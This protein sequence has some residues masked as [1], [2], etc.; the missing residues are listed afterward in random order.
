[1]DAFFFSHKTTGAQFVLVQT[2]VGAAYFVK[3]C[4]YLFQL[5]FRFVSLSHLLNI[6][7]ITN[8]KAFKNAHMRKWGINYSVPEMWLYTNFWKVLNYV[9]SSFLRNAA[10]MYQR[11]SGLVPSG[12]AVLTEPQPQP[13][14]LLI[15]EFPDRLCREREAAELQFA[16]KNCPYPF[17]GTAIPPCFP[18]SLPY[19]RSISV[20]ATDV[21]GSS[22]EYVLL[23]SSPDF[24]V[25]RPGWH[26]R[27]L[28][29]RL[30]N[31]FL[32][33]FENIWN[34][35]SDYAK[36]CTMGNAVCSWF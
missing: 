28:N 8:Q 9:L 14:I 16:R 20:W 12:P 26:L 13:F 34:Q 27:H 30:L 17:C 31:S 18:S 7:Q 23:V 35:V 33:L 2:T 36:P 15:W 25:F 21:Q 32:Y 19:S 4:I 24:L 10:G 6:S 11:G 3:M 29:D 5:P 1:M 22:I